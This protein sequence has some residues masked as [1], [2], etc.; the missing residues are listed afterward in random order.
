MT[1]KCFVCDITWEERNSMESSGWMLLHESSGWVLLHESSFV[2]MA[3]C[4]SLEID[5]V[6]LRHCVTLVIFGRCSPFHSSAYS[7]LKKTPRFLKLL[8]VKL[9]L[10]YRK[11]TLLRQCF[12]ALKLH[13]SIMSPINA[14]AHI[15]S[16][17]IICFHS[18]SCL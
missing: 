16:F 14:A 15:L 18:Q 10:F 4:S 17:Y 11:A 1:I 3:R 8:H 7:K 6:W 5:V 2:I 9:F 13:I 12:C